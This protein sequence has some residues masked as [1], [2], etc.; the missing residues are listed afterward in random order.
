MI[1][2]KL[3]LIKVENVP[4]NNIKGSTLSDA[5]G[6]AIYLK[7]DGDL[8]IICGTSNKINAKRASYII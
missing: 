7:L 5:M 8:H 4:I 3:I 2:N 1:S 6:G